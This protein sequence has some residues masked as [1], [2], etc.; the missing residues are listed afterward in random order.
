MSRSSLVCRGSF[1]EAPPGGHALSISKS[2]FLSVCYETPKFH[3]LEIFPGFGVLATRV[4]KREGWGGSGRLFELRP[5]KS[6][7]LSE[8]ESSWSS[9]LAREFWLKEGGALRLAWRRNRKP[10]TAMRIPKRRWTLKRMQQL[11]HLG[12]RR[13]ARLERRRA[14]AAG[15]PCGVSRGLPRPGRRSYRTAPCA[16]EI[17]PQGQF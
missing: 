2:G 9:W 4:P 3:V 14:G 10:L 5:A 8:E 1:E 12:L 16:Q 6:C 17:R 15:R 13:R 11:T 7:S